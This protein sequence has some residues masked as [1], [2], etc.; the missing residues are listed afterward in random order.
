M[1]RILGDAS[2]EE[3]ARAG[4]DISSYT[5]KL[6]GLTSM[7]EMGHGSKQLNMAGGRGAGMGGKAHAGRVTSSIGH[8]VIGVA[9]GKGEG[10]LRERFARGRGGESKR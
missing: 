4:I 5:T 1:R 7:F 8:A 10:Y 3:A 2:R 9:N 6:N